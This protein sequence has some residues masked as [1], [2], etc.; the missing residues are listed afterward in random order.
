V[1]AVLDVNVLIAALL[2]PNGAPAR[3]LVRW[4]TGD[5]EL[6]I[7]DHLLSEL[8]RALKYPKLHERVSANEAAA[9]IDMLKAS[10][11]I[12]PDPPRPPRRS[13]D[14]G[15]DYLLALAASCSAVLVTGDRDILDLGTDLPIYTPSRFLAALDK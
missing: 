15:D 1:R 9:L 4:L 2:A 5:F 8:G 6:I 11:T 7:S 10:A 13:R 12:A 3:L 14:A